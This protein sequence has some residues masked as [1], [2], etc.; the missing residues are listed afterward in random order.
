LKNLTYVNIIKIND[1]INKYLKNNI[2][3]MEL[4]KKINADFMT[5][6]KEKKMD[7]KNFLGVIKGDVKNK[8]GDNA[9]DSD[10]LAIVKK[11]E[12]SLKEVGTEEANQELS[13]L[14]PYLP[15]M[16]SNE[17]TK[18]ILDEFIK[19]QENVNIRSIMKHFNQNYKGLVDNKIVQV[20]AKEVI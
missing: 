11:M 3:F 4:I 18:N 15:K 9:S 10:V 20:L 19:T 8:F 7:K 6:Y 13:Y 16:M 5:A 17:E 2:I 14:E 1:I 12:K